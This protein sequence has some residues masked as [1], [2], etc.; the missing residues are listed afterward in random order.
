MLFYAT[1]HKFYTELYRPGGLGPPRGLF[2]TVGRSDQ[3]DQPIQPTRPTDPIWGIS[4]KCGIFVI[5]ALERVVD[6]LICKVAQSW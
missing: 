5:F 1:Q 2:G 3:P 4:I 6:V